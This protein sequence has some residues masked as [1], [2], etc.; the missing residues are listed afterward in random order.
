MDNP[1]MLQLDGIHFVFLN[2]IH[3]KDLICCFNHKLSGYPGCRQAEETVVVRGLLW[4]W[5]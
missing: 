1:R 5:R 2:Q 3:C 4:Y